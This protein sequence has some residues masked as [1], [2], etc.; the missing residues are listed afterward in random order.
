MDTI[1][2]VIDERLK[3]LKETENDKIYV[4]RAYN[5]QVKLNYFLM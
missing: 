5:K 4:A 1:D 3:A 2:E